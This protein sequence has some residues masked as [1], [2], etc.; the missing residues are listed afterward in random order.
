MATRKKR[1]PNRQYFPK[2][3]EDA[4]IEYNL[5]NDQYIKD[6]LYR[7]RIASAFEK[8]AEIVYNLSLI[9]I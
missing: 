2:D 7:E 6:K 3:T 9:H 1:G 5:T 4:I 8:L